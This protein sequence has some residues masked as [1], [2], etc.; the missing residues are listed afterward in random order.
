MR[1]AEQFPANRG[2]DVVSVIVADIERQVAIDSLKRAGPD[3]AASS[4]GADGVIDDI[5]GPASKRKRARLPA[6]LAFSRCPDSQRLATWC[7]QR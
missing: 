6:D 5:C 7:S 3:Q 1:L 4:A 2:Q